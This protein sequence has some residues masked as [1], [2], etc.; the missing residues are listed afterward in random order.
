VRASG[1]GRFPESWLTIP[2]KE[3]RFVRQAM[4]R[5]V[6][7]CTLRA[8]T[9]LSPTPKIKCDGAQWSP[10]WVRRGSGKARSQG[11]TDTFAILRAG[12]R[13]GAANG[14][15]RGVRERNWLLL[16]VSRQATPTRK[17]EVL[18]PQAEGLEEAQPRSIHQH[19][20]ETLRTVQKAPQ[21]REIRSLGSRTVVPQ[22]ALRPSP[23][24][25]RRS[26][27]VVTT[28]SPLR[29]PCITVL[30]RQVAPRRIHRRASPR[31][32]APWVALV[33]ELREVITLSVFTGVRI[34]LATWPPR[35][36][37]A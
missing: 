21:P 32:S 30:S 22:P 37:R 4:S 8:S 36:T 14:G 34:R 20:D 18:H 17:I 28:I 13:R 33:P 12:G 27:R 24:I 1:E 5:G 3:T 15:L 25:P 29:Q 19:G 31:G 16:K 2:N 23:S 26:S 6:P 7:R 35:T 10:P 11:P 9:S